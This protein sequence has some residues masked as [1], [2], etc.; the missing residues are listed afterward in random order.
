MIGFL[1][2]IP[3]AILAAF[4]WPKIQFGMLA[5]QGFVKGAGAL[6]IWVFVFLREP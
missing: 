4:V 6:G 3:V 2:L 1:Y 5:F